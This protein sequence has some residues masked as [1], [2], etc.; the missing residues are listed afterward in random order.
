MARITTKG[1]VSGIGSRL[2]LLA[3]HAQET[4]RKSLDK[5][6]HFVPIDTSIFD[7]TFSHLG[8]DPKL[9]EE[10]VRKIVSKYSTI[11]IS[12]FNSLTAD[13]IKII[14]KSGPIALEYNK[15]VIGV[16]FPSFG[17]VG[18]RLTTELNSRL[19]ILIGK[20]V[21][22]GHLVSN[23]SIARSP[24][25]QK[26]VLIKKALNIVL[27]SG[28]V[29]KL[30]SLI[31]AELVPHYEELLSNPKLLQSTLKELKV[32]S[33]IDIQDE[34]GKISKVKLK[35]L[36]NQSIISKL[37]S[38][39]RANNDRTRQLNTIYIPKVEQGLKDLERKSSYGNIIVES[40]IIKK[41]S[42]KLAS[43]RANIIIIQESTENQVDYGSRIE[44]A[45]DRDIKNGVLTN[46][47]LSQHFSPSIKEDIEDSIVDNIIGKSHRDVNSTM[48]TSSI[49][50]FNKGLLL[51]PSVKV[52]KA[53]PEK[54]SL[55]T[56][57][58]RATTGAFQS[59]ANLQAL[60]QARLFDTIKKNMAPPALTYKSGRFAK[61]VELKS[62]HYDNR[63]NA[64][65]AFLTYMKYPYATFEPGNARG[66]TDRSPTGLI[67]RSIREIAVSLTK[68]RL[69]AIVA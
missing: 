30:N 23:T 57:R 18:T 62:L 67:T 36:I 12:S 39:S 10:E 6:P 24:F 8:I 19:K 48:K 5:K 47:L 26:L 17:N 29:Q 32:N 38:A 52:A 63:E 53:K 3:K 68:A 35:S 49:I 15:T 25:Q 11:S 7:M 44:G 45:I 37:G 59:T 27:E 43:I 21:D 13:K 34:L 51:K 58:L 69:K 14:L 65:T 42:G 33:I 4:S 40:D 41:I 22:R 2:E 66:N 60:I 55:N 54:V 1:K 64:L 20:S 9:I 61:S 16:L 46:I 56:T 31:L 50:T 28:N